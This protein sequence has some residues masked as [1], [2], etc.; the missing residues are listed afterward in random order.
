VKQRWLRLGGAAILTA[1][2]AA[3]YMGGAP[4]TA[5]A[6]TLQ[7]IAGQCK[8]L[9]PQTTLNALTA[10][11]DNA[12]TWDMM[13][14]VTVNGG[15]TAPDGGAELQI[16]IETCAT[17]APSFPNTATGD[18]GAQWQACYYSDQTNPLNSAPN[19]I[20]VGTAADGAPIYDGP[21]PAN[22]G[23]RYC[24]WATRN[25]GV[26]DDWGVAY[27]DQIGQYTF[28][29]RANLVANN[30]TTKTVTDASF[31]IDGSGFFAVTVYAPYNWT[32]TTQAAAPSG[33]IVNVT[34]S[35]PTIVASKS[36]NDMVASGEAAQNVGLP[37]NTCTPVISQCFQ[38]LVGLL[39]TVS[40]APGFED[41]SPVVIGCTKTLGSGYDVGLSPIGF[42]LGAVE[43]P[44]NPLAP[45]LG[46]S[47]LCIASQRNVGVPPSSYTFDYGRLFPGLVPG[48][49]AL[50][51]SGADYS[52]TGQYLDYSGDSFTA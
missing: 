11:N 27:F 26:A 15:F 2:V 38:G 7:T 33:S 31:A 13:R 46:A 48:S 18:V 24:A 32:S 50:D 4:I 41:C 19:G 29:D 52:G 3:G 6:A 8:S 37:S 40:W 16:V 44:I 35:S 23:W 43:T 21:Y 30:L 49:G 36:V 47:G 34:T 28:L 25:A 10:S 12:R 20:Q 17:S 5:H 45:C 39:T 14:N 22:Q 42:P 1:G 9:N 51:A